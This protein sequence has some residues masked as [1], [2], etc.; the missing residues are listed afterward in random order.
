MAV[1]AMGHR[2]SD[3]VP[4]RP[5]PKYVLAVPQFSYAVAADARA[6]AAARSASSTLEHALAHQLGE[7]KRQLTVQGDSLARLRTAL[8]ALARLEVLYA[9]PVAGGLGRDGARSARP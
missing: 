3:P 1:I 2:A 5:T 8:A 7:A 6:A 4:D 9:A